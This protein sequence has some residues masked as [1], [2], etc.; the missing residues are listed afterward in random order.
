MSTFQKTIIIGNI[1][2][3]PTTTH[4]ENGQVTQLSIAT[5]EH[6]TDKNTNEKKERTEWH[7]VVLSGKL[8]ELGEKYLEKGSKVLIEGKLKTREWT[9]G[10][11][12]T[13][14]ST[15]IN[16]QTMTFLS[17]QKPQ[18][19]PTSAVDDYLEKH[20]DTI[21]D[22]IPSDSKEFDDLPL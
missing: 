2:T 17:S 6:W 3:E 20:K 8:S 11:G 1:G 22:G 14:Y 19:T 18:S 15:E 13:R 5:T 10:Q 16:A 12:V 9:D 21:D 7:R 4:F